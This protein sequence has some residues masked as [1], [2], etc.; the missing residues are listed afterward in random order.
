MLLFRSFITKKRSQSKGISEVFRAPYCSANLGEDPPP[1]P[2]R[3]LQLWGGH[4][5]LEADDLG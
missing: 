3:D 2:P 1:P 4:A 5:A